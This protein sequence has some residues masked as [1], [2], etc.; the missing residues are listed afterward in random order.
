LGG[1]HPMHRLLQGDVGAGK[2]VVAVSALLT[3]VQGGH[4]GALMAPTEVLAEQ[5]AAG[6][7]ELLAEL[8]VAGDAEEGSL[9]EGMATERPVRVE[10]LT[11][12]T[13]AANRRKLAEALTAGEVDILIGTHALIE[14]AVAFR[15]LGV[16][17]VDEQ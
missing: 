11:N 17:V 4:Q 8:T 10:L 7:R 3:A 9:F 12:R 1:P 13:T 14:D 5:H 6:I 15:S 16:V 2:T